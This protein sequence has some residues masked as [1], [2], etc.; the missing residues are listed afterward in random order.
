MRRIV[1]RQAA[2]L[3]D[4]A[5][6]LAHHRHRAQLFV[7]TSQFANALA[8]H[9]RIRLVTHSARRLAK[10]RSVQ[11]VIRERQERREEMALMVRTEEMALMVRTEEMV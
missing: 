3:M 6:R 11:K 5:S 8:V 9:H 1:V 7:R 4:H 2:I 10:L